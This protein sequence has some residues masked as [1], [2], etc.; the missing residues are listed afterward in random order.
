MR[1][2]PAGMTRFLVRLAPEITTKS[3]QT[4][5]R[6]QAQLVGNIQDA[7]TDL[8]GAVAVDDRWTRIVVDAASADAPQRVARLFG[9]SS[10]SVVDAT[11]PADLEV[12]V[13][14]G[15]TLYREDVRR[16]G[17][18][19]VSARRH[20]AHGFS[21]R[22]VSVEL[23]AALNPYG[24]VNLGD[25]GVTVSVDVRDKE[26][27]LFQE[28]VEGLGGLPLGAQGAAVC[29][30]SG[31]FDSA[32]AAWLLLKRGITLEYVFC[33]LAGAAYERSVASV[34]RVLAEEW[35]FG[36]RPRL[37][38][39][40]FSAVVQDLRA[41]VTPRYWQVVLKRL[42]YRAADAVA[43]EVGGEA[44]VTGEALGQVS[45][46]TLANLR[47]IDDV[48]SLPVLRPL[49]GYEKIEIIRLAERVGTSALSARV[50]E[51]CDMVTERPVTGA[52]VSAV[53][54][55]E[56]R[57][58]LAFLRAAVQARKV[59]DLRALTDAD[60]VEPYVYTDHVHEG[61]VVIDCRPRHQYQTWHY[62]GALPHTTDAVLES[63]RTL[64]KET[65]YVL[66]CEVGIRTA[67]VAEVLQRLGYAVYSFRGG[68][69][70]LREWTGSHAPVGVTP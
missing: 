67:P 29:L 60:F 62:E 57:V 10:V 37:H 40:D 20:G 23:G 54:N 66:Y 65:P 31:G 26:A 4:R 43:A 22:D 44:I 27:Y 28:R 2:L 58:D 38:V 1:E 48:A 17:T 56:S 18:F 69:A 15:L 21:S 70:A 53:R 51:H 45:S 30:L 16:A 25:P 63:V 34:A 32:A 6:F 36:Y 42:M 33:N 68:A 41:R 14:T 8:G 61:A 13:Q 49:L 3:R 64:E 50:H 19:A 7:L 12:I 59:L 9:V 47:A 46:Q 11:V 52:R 35:S 5:R 55:E 24:E 39:I